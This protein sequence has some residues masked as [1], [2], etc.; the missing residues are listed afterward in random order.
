[1][2]ID[3]N[4][5]DGCAVIDPDITEIT[6]PGDLSKENYLEDI[7]LFLKKNRS[8]RVISI[9]DDYLDPLDS[10]TRYFC[11]RVYEDLPEIRIVWVREFKIDGRHGR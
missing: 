4:A 9:C 2:Q 7:F 1:M 5:L 6:V 3:L 10:S 8:V 11:R